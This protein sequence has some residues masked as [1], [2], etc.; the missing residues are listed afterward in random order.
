MRITLGNKDSFQG[1]RDGGKD[2]DKQRMADTEAGIY[3]EGVT[4]LGE[5]YIGMEMLPH[6][7]GYI[8]IETLRWGED[9]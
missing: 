1:G 3:W 6:R 7:R 4:V 9:I 2:E 8:G 5:G